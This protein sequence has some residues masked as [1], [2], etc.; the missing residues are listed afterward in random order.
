MH[1]H[2]MLLIHIA[3]YMEYIGGHTIHVWC[4]WGSTEIIQG[5]LA[6]RQLLEKKIS[7]LTGTIQREQSDAA[8]VC[9]KK[10]N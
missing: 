3:S 7:T 10:T 4:C 8:D 5:H 6:K 2:N 1:Q 9:K